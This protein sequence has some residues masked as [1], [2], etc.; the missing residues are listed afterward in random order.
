MYFSL[1]KGHQWTRQELRQSFRAVFLEGGRSVMGHSGQQIPQSKS[2]SAAVGNE[3]THK[4]ESTKIRI[5]VTVG[6]QQTTLPT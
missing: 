2:T 6:T 5:M 3:I 4:A 1:G